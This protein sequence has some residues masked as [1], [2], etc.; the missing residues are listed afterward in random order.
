MSTSRSTHERAA[1]VGIVLGVVFTTMGFV[2][3]N[4]GIWIPGL[5]VLAIGIWS[6]QKAEGRAGD[7]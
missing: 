2:Y 1:E 3:G 7:S 5:I 4:A 6:K